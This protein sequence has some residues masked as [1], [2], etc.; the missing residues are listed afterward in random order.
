MLSPA[1]VE[2][3]LG[4]AVLWKGGEALEAEVMQHFAAVEKLVG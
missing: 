3:A 2:R 4:E 1:A